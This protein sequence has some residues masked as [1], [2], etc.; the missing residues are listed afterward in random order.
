MISTD[1]RAGARIAVQ[2]LLDQSRR[3]IGLI[4]GPLDWWEARERQKGWQ[5]A[6][7]TA[8]SQVTPELVA[9]GSWSAASGAQAL[10]DL[11]T[12]QPNIDAVFASNDQMALGVLRSA[13]LLGRRVPDDL[14]VVGYDNMPESAFFQPPLTSV[15]QHLRNLGHVA[16]RELQV[17]IDARRQEETPEQPVTHL[18]APDLI[19]RESSISAV[20]ELAAK[21]TL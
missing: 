5:E 12:Q 11:L 7:Q 8:G 17:A 13:A 3:R 21:L 2:H 1:N 19:I 9:H 15:R 20:Q 18:L 6:L 16:V 4:T 10:H 14:A